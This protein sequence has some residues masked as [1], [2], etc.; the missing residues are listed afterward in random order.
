MTLIIVVLQFPQLRCAVLSC[1]ELNGQYTM[2]QQR[3]TDQGTELAQARVDY[4]R[5]SV[6]LAESHSKVSPTHLCAGALYV[7]VLPVQI[8][9]VEHAAKQQQ[10]Q[11]SGST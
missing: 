3:C 9:L 8:N 4:K 5:A 6:E 10:Q 2:L 7:I 1:E 11:V